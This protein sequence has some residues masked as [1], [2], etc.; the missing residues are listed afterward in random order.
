MSQDE[1]RQKIKTISAAFRIFLS[2]G[3]KTS[4]NFLQKER[5][6]KLFKFISLFQ[7]SVI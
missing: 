7:K 5:E 4:Q 1:T 6:K 3:D 2:T